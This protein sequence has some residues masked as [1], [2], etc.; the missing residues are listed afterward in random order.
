[1][2]P[3]F[4]YFGG[5]HSS[6]GK[7]PKP[8]HDTIIE[9]F[10]GSAGYSHR[11]WNRNVILIEKDPTLCALWRFLIGAS[12]LDIL[13]LPLLSPGQTVRSLGLDAG[14]SALIGFW[15]SNG[16]SSPRQTLSSWARSVDLTTRSEF[17]GSA[18]RARLSRNVARMNHWQL[19]EGDYTKAPD[20]EATWF[21]DPPYQVQGRKYACGAQDIDFSALGAWCRTRRG[22]VMVCEN[23]G[24]D[25]LPFSYMHRRS[26]ARKEGDKRKPSHEAIWL[27]EPKENE[28]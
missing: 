20:V 1:M 13:S 4:S 10:A 7:Y 19:I 25:W 26:G 23:V 18:C 3:S 17:W 28:A 6:S 14:R 24:A 16:A 5:K 22:R 9:P 21:I 15:V 12:A 27:N 11:Y 2:P 8:R